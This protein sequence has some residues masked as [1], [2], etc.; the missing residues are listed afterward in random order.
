MK[1]HVLSALVFCFSLNLRADDTNA[2][3]VPATNIVVA[4]YILTPPAPAT[5][6]INGPDVFGVRPGS[7]FLY[8][9]PVTGDRPM[10]FS[11]DNLPSG[12]E[13][14]PQT[15]HITGELHKRISHRRRRPDCADAADGL[16][17]LELFRQRG[18]GRQGQECCGRNGEERAH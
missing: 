8:T 18:F 14:D 6:R 12:L 11:A 2:P 5:P 17:Q 16:E 1:L 3:V 15:G 13:L 7:P 4:P 9:I 10:A